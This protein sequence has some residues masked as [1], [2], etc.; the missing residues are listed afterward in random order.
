MYL[1]RT[2]RGI[3]SDLGFL[4]Y[5]LE[6][7][8]CKALKRANAE[9]RLLT[10]DAQETRDWVPWIRPTHGVNGTIPYAATGFESSPGY[11][12]PRC[13][14]SANPHRD[15]ASCIMVVKATKTQGK[16]TQNYFQAVHDYHS[17]PYKMII[18]SHRALP[19]PPSSFT[20]D[21]DA[22]CTTR[23][24]SPPPASSQ[25]MSQASAGSSELSASSRDEIW[26][27]NSYFN[28]E[29]AQKRAQPDYALVMA[30]LDEEFDRAQKQYC[31]PTSIDLTLPMLDPYRTEKWPVDM[32]NFSAPIGHLLRQLN[33]NIGVTP[34]HILLI[35]DDMVTCVGCRCCF[36]FRGYRDHVSIVDGNCGN[37]DIFI[38]VPSPE[39][40]K[41]I[42][43]N[44]HLLRPYRP[45]Y[46]SQLKNI[47]DCIQ[48]IV[49]RAWLDY[50]SHVGV[51]RDVYSFIF[52]TRVHCEACNRVRS[53]AGHGAHNA[54]DGSCTVVGRID[55]GD[56]EDEDD[57][58]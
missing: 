26:R 49:G 35:S 22:E 54:P 46:P 30:Y 53:F 12:A 20:D 37:T 36:S 8:L 17:C 10:F 34:Q 19:L 51:P 39:S 3:P 18:P 13:P 28:R 57:E 50:N 43:E 45:E 31:G 7:R 23:D 33:S 44:H 1:A 48:S 32:R 25:S 55:R 16:P 41:R 58:E 6:V 11:V 42:P 29:T 24:S 56:G 38:I 2:P 5:R 21:E 52:G 47:A 4:D 9:G 40:V 27:P 14:H 15:A